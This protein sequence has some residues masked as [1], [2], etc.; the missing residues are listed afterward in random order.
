MID[1]RMTLKGHALYFV[2]M[3]MVLVSMVTAAFIHWFVYY[4][5]RTE[6]LQN[7][8]LLE[9]NFLDA[10]KLLEHNLDGNGEDWFTLFSNPE[11]SVQF[12][13]KPYGIFK[14]TQV[15]VSRQGK[16][17]SGTFLLYPHE[18]KDS[19]AFYLAD[20]IEGLKMGGKSQIIGNAFLPKRK[21]ERGYAE[22]KPSTQKSLVTGKIKEGE[23]KYSVD[24]AI[25]KDFLSIISGNYFSDTIKEWQSFDPNEKSTALIQYYKS[26]S[27]V[28]LSDK[29][30]GPLV[31]I[32]D[33]KVT[34]SSSA[35]LIDIVI[36]ANEIEIQN[37]FNGTGQFYA[38]NKLDIGNHVELNYPSVVALYSKDKKQPA[39]LTTGQFSKVFGGAF[40]LDFD[41]YGG[42]LHL[43]KNSEIHGLVYSGD[44]LEIQGEIFGKAATNELYLKT[45]SS[46]Y[47]NYL[48]DAQ[49]N[50]LALDS[51][52][53]IPAGIE[54]LEGWSVIKKLTN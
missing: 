45:F 18:K 52:Y 36:I 53:L 27:S 25:K 48:I 7:D 12:I 22:G 38:M 2:L 6:T 28:N 50:R 41:G 13:T 4:D 30:T 23:S 16:I 14:V 10:Q 21:A 24:G 31:L 8:I 40:L 33:A 3:A 29:L 17:K 49:I 51:S 26:S 47:K 43:S 5:L 34:V 19:N 42:V 1:W 37:N 15:N 11:D 35:M 9:R 46:V 32:C 54:P 20:N 44:Q 39:N